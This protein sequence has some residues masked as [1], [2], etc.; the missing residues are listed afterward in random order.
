MIMVLVDLW[1]VIIIKKQL[2]PGLEVPTTVAG[3]APNESVE[4]KEEV[5]KVVSVWIRTLSPVH[6]YLVTCIQSPLCESHHV[7]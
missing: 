1:T 5:L 7:L 6:S 3:E 2:T 4:R